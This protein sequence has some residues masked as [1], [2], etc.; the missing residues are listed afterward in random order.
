MEDGDIAKSCDKET[1][2]KLQKAVVD[3]RVAAHVAKM[4][5]DFDERLQKKVDE[6]LQ[7]YGNEDSRALMEFEGNS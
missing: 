6:L 5:Q 1:W 2:K 7:A 4:Q 3:A